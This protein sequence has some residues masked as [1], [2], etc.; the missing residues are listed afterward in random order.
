[1]VLTEASPDVGRPL[2]H[3]VKHSPDGFAW[4][5]HGSGPAELARCLLIDALEDDALCPGCAGAGRRHAED[6][7]EF[8]R[9]WE[10]WGTGFG[11]AVERRYQEFKR[12]VVGTWP[13][14]EGWVITQAEILQWH[15]AN[16]ATEAV[17]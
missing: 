8:V 13:Q 2:H 12:L 6:A 17:R 15:R 3:H 10:C 1:M 7:L 4:G 14:S 9:C 5:Y 16:E 11:P